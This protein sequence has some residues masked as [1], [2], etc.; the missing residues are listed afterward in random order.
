MTACDTKR[1]SLVICYT[2]TGVAACGPGSLDRL[3]LDTD[4]WFTN[5]WTMDHTD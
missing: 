4:R 2:G 3:D 5:E 1:Y